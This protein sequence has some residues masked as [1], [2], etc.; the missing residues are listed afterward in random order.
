MQGIAEG[1]RA[2]TSVRRNVPR[3]LLYVTA[4]IG[5]AVALSHA[6]SAQEGVVG[7]AV[8]SVGQP[9]PGV[10][11]TITAPA[12]GEQRR[13][14][15]AGDGKYRFDKLA[16]GIYR[17]DFELLGFDMTRRNFV[18]VRNGSS[19]VADATLRVSAIC[20]CVMATGPPV[21]KRS[22][23]VV[24]EA[25]RPLPFARLEIAIP[26]TAPGVVPASTR[27]EVAYAD[28]EGRFSLFAPVDGTW[29]LTASD[30]G[31][32]SVTQQ[33]S[34]SVVEPIVFRLFFTGTGPEVPDEEHFSEHCL[35]SNVSLR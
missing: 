4:S 10:T 28:A 20:E 13:T 24:D 27:R 30:S 15:T 6:V 5:L 31:F 25:G 2:C 14:T 22:G 12:G 1:R 17:V 7:R 21:A 16:D 3:L 32:R 34:A 33:V 8:D 19:T 23:R 9:L 26:I 35:C 18:R 29:P 11:V